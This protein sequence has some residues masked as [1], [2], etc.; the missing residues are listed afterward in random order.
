MVIRL[1]LREIL[2]RATGIKGVQKTVKIYN[3]NKLFYAVV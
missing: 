2:P 3:S 1:L